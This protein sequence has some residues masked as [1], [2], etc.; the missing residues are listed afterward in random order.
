MEP[1]AEAWRGRARPGLVLPEGI[2]AGLI[3]GLAVAAVFLVRDVAVGEPLYTPS[4]L[5]ALLVE[6]A[7]AAARTGPTAGAAALYHAVHFFV[8][9]ALGF[10]GSALFAAVERRPSRRGLLIAAALLSLL[11][12][13]ALDAAT[14]GTALVLLQLRIGGIVGLLAMGAFLAWRHPGALRGGSTR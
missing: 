3:G 7:E 14:R 5:G 12:L 2:E 4:L 6:G 9:I 10:A 8:W 1:P 13:A 11:P